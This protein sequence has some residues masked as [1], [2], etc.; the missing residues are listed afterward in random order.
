MI[1]KENQQPILSYSNDCGL[2]GDLVQR[3]EELLVEDYK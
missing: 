2:D 3:I 1:S